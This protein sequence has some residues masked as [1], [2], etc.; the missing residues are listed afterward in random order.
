[1]AKTV[2][3]SIELPADL[4]ARLRAEAEQHGISFEDE[5][6]RRLAADEDERKSSRTFHSA[7]VGTSGHHDTARRARELLREELG[8]Q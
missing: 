4:E 6:V 1:M 2:T 5:V 8:E 7:G 3:I